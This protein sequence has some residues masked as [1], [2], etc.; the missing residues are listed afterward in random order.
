M[1]VTDSDIKSGTVKW[2]DEKKGFGF[3]IPDDNPD[4]DVFV[5]YSAVP[6]GIGRKNLLEGD[7]VTYLEGERTSGTFAIKVVSIVR[8]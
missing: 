4:L 2:F 3:I 5:H 6:G 8:S 1:I 7:K